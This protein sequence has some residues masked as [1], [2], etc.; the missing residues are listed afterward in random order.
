MCAQVNRH[1]SLCLLGWLSVSEAREPGE[2]TPK[3]FRLS[4]GSSPSDSVLTVLGSTR[5]CCGATSGNGGS[6]QMR[7]EREISDSTE[8]R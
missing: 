6:V 1:L 7:V 4:I 2:N 5:K 3:C 8:T